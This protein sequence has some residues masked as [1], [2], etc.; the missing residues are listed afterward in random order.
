ML[1]GM[2]YVVYWWYEEMNVLTSNV[3]FLYSV[4]TVSVKIKYEARQAKSQKPKAGPK[5]QKVEV[6]SQWVLNFES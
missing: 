3:M 2:T 5:C 1:I 6:G 4:L